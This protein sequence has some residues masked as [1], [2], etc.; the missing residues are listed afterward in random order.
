[1]QRCFL[2]GSSASSGARMAKAPVHVYDRG[3]LQSSRVNDAFFTR[4]FEAAR[5][6]R[7]Q[8]RT[9]RERH[10]VFVSTCTWNMDPRHSGFTSTQLA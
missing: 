3:L 9:A 5:Y 4:W 8:P 7:L 6:E 2:A 1:M 10:Q